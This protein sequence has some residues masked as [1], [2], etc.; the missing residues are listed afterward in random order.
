MLHVCPPVPLSTITVPADLALEVGPCQE[1]VLYISR[2]I[3]KAS[4]RLYKVQDL[5]HEPLRA[6]VALVVADVA[7][8]PSA[9]V[10]PSATSNQ[11]RRKLW[12]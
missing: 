7:G 9:T 6:L 4:G 12:I 2:S 3:E 8:P 11:P 10:V 5:F 1:T